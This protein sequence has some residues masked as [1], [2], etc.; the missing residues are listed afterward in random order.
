MKRLRFIDAYRGFA[1]INMI[2][3]HWFYDYV[4]IFSMPLEWFAGT[5]A[6]IWQ[7]WIV[8]SF[9]LISGLVLNYAKNPKKR[10]IF[11]C[12]CGL[13]LTF[14]TYFVVPQELIVFGILSF[15]GVAMIIT[16]LLKEYI[17]SV[18]TVFLCVFGFLLTE[19]WH[20]GY[21]GFYGLYF[22]ELTLIPPDNLLFFI[23]GIHGTSYTSADYVP[24][25]PWI[26]V[27]W[28]GTFGWAWIKCRR[29][30]YPVLEN[31]KLK[32]SPDFYAI[33]EFGGRHTLMIY[34]LHQPMLYFIGKTFL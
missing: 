28:I 6:Y 2:A 34:L 7:Q 15:L 26:F 4:N 31:I 3:Y 33:L 13:F 12:L 32:R 1:L 16:G 11:L 14:C 8:F 30:F 20:S 29:K 24:I 27:F 9:I 10:G 22:A 23:L 17:Q 18:K 21:W 19:G 5:T 25:F